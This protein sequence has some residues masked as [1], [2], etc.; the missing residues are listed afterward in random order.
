M[1]GTIMIVRT[2]IAV[3]YLVPIV[4]RRPEE[5]DE[6][7][8]RVESRVDVVAQDRGE[9]E[10]PPEP[11]D[12]AGDAASVSTSAVTGPR[13]QRGDSSVRN[14]A[15]PIASGVAM[16]SAPTD[17]IDCAVEEGGGAEVKVDRIPADVPDEPEPEGREREP[18]ALDQLPGDQPDEDESR[19]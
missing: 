10:N 1:I 16:S 15:I 2:M 19:R 5:R 6:A 13:S 7:E 18:S 12:D 8:R 3:K 14:S 9:D 4:F 11:D 17:V